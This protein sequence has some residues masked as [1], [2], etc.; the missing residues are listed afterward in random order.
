MGFLKLV[1]SDLCLYLILTLTH[2]LWQGLVVA[3]LA[4]VVTW[5]LRRASAAIRYWVHVVALLLMVACLPVTAIVLHVAQVGP[6]EEAWQITSRSLP[7]GFSEPSSNIPVADVPR[8]EGRSTVALQSPVTIRPTAATTGWNWRWITPY[9]ASAYIVGVVFMLVRLLTDLWGGHRLRRYLHPLEDSAVLEILGRQSRALEM[10]YVPAVAY[11]RRIAVPIVVGVFR[12]MILLPLSAAT[13]LTPDQIT[14]ILT[15]ELAHLRRYDPVINVLQRF[16]E[17]ILFFH[18]AV[19]YV[20][21][22]IRLEREHCCDDVVLATGG[23]PVAYAESLVRVAELSLDVPDAVSPRVATTLSASGSGRSQ[24]RGRILRLLGSPEQSRVRST[25][26]GAL[27]IAALL[28]AGVVLAAATIGATGPAED[29]Q[30]TV[31]GEAS[32]PESEAAAERSSKR[33]MLVRTVDE[34]GKPIAGALIEVCIDGSQRE[35]E[36]GTHGTVAA[37]L[38][39]EDFGY[40]R[41]VAVADGYSPLYAIWHNEKRCDPVPDEFSFTM[42]EGTTVGGIVRDEQGK[43]IKDVSVGL[44]IGTSSTSLRRVQR[45]FH[46]HVEK[47]DAGGRWQ[48]TLMPTQIDRLSLRFRHPDYVSYDT[49]WASPKPPVEK[50]R[51]M[52]AVRV[53]EKGIPV[54]GTVTDET[55][56]PVADAIVALGGK[57]YDAERPKTATDQRGQFRFA[58]CK[59]GRQVLTVVASGWAPEIRTVTLVPPSAPV[60]FQLKK[61]R[62]IRIRVINTEGKPL[63]GTRIFP[64][65]WRRR[66]RLTGLGVELLTD[67]EGRW[68]WDSAPEDA[69]KLDIFKRGHVN[70]RRRELA[71]Q[72]KEHVITLNASPPIPPPLEVS[73]RVVDAE[74]KEPIK[75]F[76]VIPCFSLS[77]RLDDAKSGRDGRYSIHLPGEYSQH[78]LRVEAPGYLSRATRFFKT[79]ERT[80]TYDLELTK[81][82]AVAGKILRPDGTPLEG[83]EVLLYSSHNRPR[84]E[85]GRV[86]RD[87]RNPDWVTAKTAPD[88]SFSLAP[89]TK[90]YT[91]MVMDD[92]GFAILGRDELAQVSQITLQPWARVE[93]TLRIGSR[94]VANESIA[95]MPDYPPEDSSLWKNVKSFPN[96]ETQTDQRGRFVFDR[97]FPGR[98]DIYRALRFA[99]S[100]EGDALAAAQR[101]RLD[102]ALGESVKI[103]LGGKGRP[104]IGRVVLPE[105]DDRTI[106]WTFCSGYFDPPRGPD[107]RTIPG[108][109]YGFI[110][111]PDGSFRCEDVPGGSYELRIYA[112]RLP[113]RQRQRIETI[114]RE[115]TVPKSPGGRSDE[116]FDLGKLQLIIAK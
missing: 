39:E 85:N 3:A 55:G 67:E 104:V 99:V 91:L 42:E 70:I 36:T 94:P 48:C 68:V 95:V 87:F 109:G 74:T 75:S 31:S 47:T 45:W 26:L 57:H 28:A 40:L 35:Y 52:T 14:A 5:R 65:T 116:P 24:L 17:A 6:I 96:Y 113:S 30:K 106:D 2:F 51:A 77:S 9:F 27:A 15:H 41:V 63:A 34:A 4:A 22:R 90:S 84:L 105:G 78:I 88:G 33:T 108:F 92:A 54:A 20:S 71:T 114:R 44:W 56:T 103:E 111:N 62:T 13:S 100:E 7:A 12:P 66:R 64:N 102:L 82:A 53:M 32:Q 19:W 21:R 86:Q 98:I 46:K 60:D 80:V 107:G 83:A 29:D 79:S 49:Y 101:V 69:V 18:P 23:R 72:E 97:L 11:C 73:G 1:D 61:G 110:L 89:W 76:R 38:L 37:E 25:P 115:I 58:H 59:P 93:G 10:R 43:P 50:L 81:A 8:R 112:D 16:V